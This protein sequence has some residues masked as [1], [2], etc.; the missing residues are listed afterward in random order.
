M[1][2]YD[3]CA[4]EFQY[5]KP[6]DFNQLMGGI[7]SG[8]SEEAKPG[9][10]G[11]DPHKLMVKK[12]KVETGEELPEM[13]PDPKWPAA[14]IKAL[15][16]YC[17]RMGIIGFS[18]RQHPRLALAQLKQQMG[19]MSNIPLENRIPLGYEKVGTFNSCTSK[20]SLI[21]G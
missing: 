17:Q 21:A 20:K 14:D 4:G 1:S 15:Q 11:Y 8:K 2:D 9:P 19:D 6:P 7:L 5:S 13:P 16:D 10:N 18:T 3:H 12:H